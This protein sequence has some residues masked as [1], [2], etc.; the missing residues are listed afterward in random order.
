VKTRAEEIR[1]LLNKAQEK[2]AEQKIRVSEEEAKAQEAQKLVA[3]LDLVNNSLKH[4]MQS[5]DNVTSEH[6]QIQAQLHM[7]YQELQPVQALEELRA[8]LASKQSQLIDVETKL[9]Q[10]NTLI[11]ELVTKKSLSENLKSKI[12]SLQN[13]PTCLQSVT[14]DH[15]HSIIS[16]ENQKLNHLDKIIADNSTNKR[17]SEDLLISLKQEIN[18]LITH[19]QQ[20]LLSNAK[21]KTYE[22]K[23]NRL[24][25]L[26][27][28][29]LEITNRIS[30]LQKNKEILS[31]KTETHDFT[32]K[33]RMARQKL[34]ALQNEERQ[35]AIDY[36][37]LAKEIEGIELYSNSIEEEI[38]QKEQAKKELDALA[39]QQ[40]WLQEHFM[41]LMDVMEKHVLSRVHN[42]FNDLFQRWFSILIED[43]LLNAR[44]DDS[45][46]PVMTQN[47]HEVSVSNLSGGE[48]TACA[49]AYRLALNKVIN[50][51][52]S[53]IKTK[54][55]LILDEPTDGFSDEQLDKIRDVL[56][57]L[58]LRQVILVSHENKIESM[59][60]NVIRIE[61]Q[62]H[63]SSVSTT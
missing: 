50:D 57:E 10:A 13:C 58:K 47:G 24:N 51:V 36:N 40:Y 27:Q 38:A 12:E 7:L 3:E 41:N 34:D 28:N 5:L 1:L 39:I 33:F 4:T 48:K 46:T 8:S 42:E 15:K 20:A 53:T 30:D 63:V 45:F 62:G 26:Q 52:V 11:T 56:D 2:A 14:P 19:E 44:L 22:E 18:Q 16:V 9:K 23:N 59:V 61:K 29:K 49:L 43:D 6:K 25:L 21:R 55:I 35:L 37:K 32:E 31:Q 17:A 60:Q 54:D